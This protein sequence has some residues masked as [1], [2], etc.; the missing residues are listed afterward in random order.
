MGGER[1][2]RERAVGLCDE[3]LAARPA[4]GIAL[5]YAFCVLTERRSP[6][7]VSER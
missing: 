2:R 7:T 1:V 5:D 6:L 3:E 4:A